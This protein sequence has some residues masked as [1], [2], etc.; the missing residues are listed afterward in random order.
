MPS[1]VPVTST[2]SDSVIPAGLSTEPSD[3]LA[4]GPSAFLSCS[5]ESEAHLHPAPLSSLVGPA[6][7]RYTYL[8]PQ[9][10][11]SR[12]PSSRTSRSGF[13]GYRAAQLA[14]TLWALC[15]DSHQW[16]RE[17]A[18]SSRSHPLSLLFLTATILKNCSYFLPGEVWPPLSSPAEMGLTDPASRLLVARSQGAFTL[19]LSG[20]L[21]DQGHW[22]RPPSW[23]PLHAACSQPL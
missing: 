3:P 4:C 8:H 16:L 14:A 10:L 6:P 13:G 19:C 17:K 2:D 1:Q 23:T 18:V 7:H 21:R 20:L 9:P 22:S 12:H 11:A 5:P 15:L